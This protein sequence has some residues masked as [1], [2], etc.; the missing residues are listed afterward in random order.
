VLISQVSPETSSTCDLALAVCFTSLLSTKQ[1]RKEACSC[2]QK[3][4][5]CRN[6]TQLQAIQ[7]GDRQ[8]VRHAQ[9]TIIII[10]DHDRMST[11]IDSTPIRHCRPITRTSGTT[12]TETVIIQRKKLVR[13]SS[14]DW[15]T[16]KSF[17]MGLEMLLHHRVY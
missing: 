5:R 11:P 4:Y 2:Q 1:R 3:M 12:C 14:V 6:C 9:Y 7:G 17:A 10:L 16:R 13:G 8:S 15:P